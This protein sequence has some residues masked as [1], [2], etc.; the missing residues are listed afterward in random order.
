MSICNYQNVQ[1][2]SQCCVAIISQTRFPLLSMCPIHRHTIPM[3]IS[4]YSDYIFTSQRNNFNVFYQ[5]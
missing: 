3:S 2:Q 5:I 4:N 1:P